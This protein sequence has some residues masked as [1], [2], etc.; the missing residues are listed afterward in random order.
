[1]QYEDIGE[2]MF[3]AIVMYH[4]QQRKRVFFLR[5]VY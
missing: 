3:M 4:H 1:M 2:N 5:D